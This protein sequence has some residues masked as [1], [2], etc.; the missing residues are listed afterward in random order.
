MGMS[1]VMLND[2]EMERGN[3]DSQYCMCAVHGIS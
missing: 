1:A 2:P 3:P